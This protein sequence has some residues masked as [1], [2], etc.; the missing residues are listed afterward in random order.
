MVADGRHLWNAG[1]F[2]FRVGDILAAF[3]AYAPDMVA[4]CRRA[5]AEATEDLGFVRLSPAYGEVRAQS[6]DY[7][8]MEPAGAVPGRVAAV[9]VSAGWSDLGSWPA[10]F[11]TKH[12]DE[13]G[14]VTEGAATA[15]DCEAT[16]LRSEDAHL[17]LV[18]LGLRN[19]VA[20]AMRDAVLVADMDRA[21]DVK[22]VVARLTGA[23]VSQARDYPR[24][25]RPWGWYE[26]LCLDSRFQVKRIM[27]KP[28]GTLSLQ[29]HVHRSEHWVVV[30]GT[31]R[32]TVDDD[33]LV[34]Q[35][36]QSVHVPLGARH[37]IENPG[38]LPMQIIEV[39]CGGYLGEDDIVRY[40]DIYGRC[41]GPGVRSTDR[42][43]P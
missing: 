37:R 2:L 17:Q 40:D 39:Q 10:L 15:V 30:A 38:D 14:V 18:G 13:R 41:P 35:P 3:E 26:T 25:H 20:V 32:V 16:Y 11:A 21:Q 33:V 24:F 23:G 8:V 36:N 19:I 34:L 4:P 31:A 22:G 43:L 29:S 5:L 9:P 1:V 28:G 7:A 6:F 12:G 27:V 42:R